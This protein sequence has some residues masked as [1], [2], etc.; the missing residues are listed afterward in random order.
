MATRKLREIAQELNYA[1]TDQV[2]EDIVLRKTT[3]AWLKCEEELDEIADLWQNVECENDDA[4][5]IEQILDY[6]IKNLRNIKALS[7]LYKGDKP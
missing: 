4:V 7:E 6:R 5:R 2:S 3:E 1:I